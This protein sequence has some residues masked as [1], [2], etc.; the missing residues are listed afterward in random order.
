MSIRPLLAFLVCVSVT[1]AWAQAGDAA[2]GKA[3]ATTCAA[4][5]GPDGNSVNPEWPKIASQHAAYAE[6]QLKAFKAGK[7]RSNALM[8]VMAAP[9]SEQ[10]MKDL[11]AYFASM[12]ASGGNAEA[13]LVEL[14]KKLYRGGNPATGVPAC[15]SCHG[16]AGEGDPRAQF[17]R[18]AGQHA[19]YT[20]A[21][22]ESYRLGTRSTDPQRMMR[23][24]ALK[25]TPDE[26]TAVASYIGG[27]H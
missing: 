8:T 4:C 3:K 15:M 7:H 10:D 22:L 1:P 9:L 23:D 5:H 12:P 27:L 14:G 24:I 26:M 21:Q 2:A 17:P 25:L 18:L 13:A 16:P 11:S 20:K 19:V 6:A